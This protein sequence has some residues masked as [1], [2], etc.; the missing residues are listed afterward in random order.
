MFAYELFTN[1]RKLKDSKI[2]KLKKI[3]LDTG[4]KN[5]NLIQYHDGQVNDVRLCIEIAMEAKSLGAKVFN[6][7]QFNSA[8]LVD[9]KWEIE[10]EDLIQNKKYIVSAEH[11]INVSG[12]SVLDVHKRA[13]LK[14]SESWPAVTF[15]TGVHLYFDYKWPEAGLI[16]PAEKKGRYYFVL[17]TF[18]PYKSGV[19]V[20]TTDTKVENGTCYPEPTEGE[21]NQIMSLLKRDLPQLGELKP[22]K[23]ISGMRVLAGG[24]QSS[25]KL[26]RKE[27]ILL[28]KN[29]VTILSGKYTTARASAKKILE[30]LLDIK[31]SVNDLVLSNSKG[32]ST[33]EVESLGSD[34]E[35]EKQAARLRF[36][37]IGSGKKKFNI[38]NLENLI[39]DQIQYCLDN[40]DAFFWEDIFDRRLN[41]DCISNEHKIHKAYSSIKASYFK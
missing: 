26:D 3:L 13:N 17:P 14:W 7:M 24:G 37:E 4:F 32:Y 41:V 25:H 6:Y 29:Y 22:H 27:K 38:S 8:K 34:L 18:S 15:S 23:I 39:S 36:G 21:V 30:Q 5:K 28:E 10:T 20:G 12:A 2:K 9:D 33:L 40:E 35:L 1:S 16:L 11:L 31:I 19:L